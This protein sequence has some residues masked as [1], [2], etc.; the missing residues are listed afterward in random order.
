MS[1]HTDKP[2]APYPLS[3]LAQF[4]TDALIDTLAYTFSRNAGPRPIWRRPRPSMHG[5][6]N[7]WSVI[8][9]EEEINE[10]DVNS[11]LSS[12]RNRLPAV[13]L[14]IVSISI[15]CMNQPCVYLR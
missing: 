13:Y 6:R 2:S 15:W 3:Y 7:S 9:L 5:S 10:K 12:F 11:P 1:D 8:H 14:V 4:V